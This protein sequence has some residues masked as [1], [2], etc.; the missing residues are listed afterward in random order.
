M[1][2]A[3]TTC[4]DY[5]GEHEDE[6]GA[7][8]DADSEGG[9][10]ISGSLGTGTGLPTKLPVAWREQPGLGP[11]VLHRFDEEQKKGADTD[12][13]FEALTERYSALFYD[14][15]LL[16]EL[17]GQAARRMIK[18]KVEITPER[19]ETWNEVF[20]AGQKS[21]KEEE[22]D[23]SLI[24]PFEPTP[25]GKGQ[26]LSETAKNLQ[27]SPDEKELNDTEARVLELMILDERDKETIAKR[28]G[29][30]EFAVKGAMGGIYSKYAIGGKP[31]D[32]PDEAVKIAK[33]F[34][35]SLPDPTSEDQEEELPPFAVDILL[36]QAEIAL[37][38]G[39]S[40]ILILDLAGLSQG[41]IADE[42]QRTWQSIRTSQ[43]HL[44]RKLG[45]PADSQ[46]REKMD[47]RRQRTRELIFR[48]AEP[49]EDI[50]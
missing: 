16:I 18:A 10:D 33:E 44:N 48:H 28:I 50:I 7:G 22:D 38:E 19:L 31:M 32:K 23:A 37:S 3:A 26:K 21:K 11:W 20:G 5:G 36:G 40:Q 39:D 9:I 46:P 30:S 47:L 12:Q 1:S 25:D 14:R 49:Q 15:E 13:A 42:L 41:E 35:N 29:V 43:T 17:G 24:P 34:L 6:E 8:S 27:V 4:E 2:E 45:V